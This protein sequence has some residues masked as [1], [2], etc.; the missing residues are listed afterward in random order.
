MNNVDREFVINS[1]G[2][3]INSDNSLSELLFGCVRI[4]RKYNDGI[5]EEERKEFVDILKKFNA[6][7][8]LNSVLYLFSDPKKLESFINKIETDKLRD[9]LNKTFK[10]YTNLSGLLYDCVKIYLNYNGER[11]SEQD[12]IREEKFISILKEYNECIGLEFVLDY[13]GD[14]KRLE[15]FIKNNEL[16]R[17]SPESK[18]GIKYKLEG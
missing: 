6:C 12:E 11:N 1:L 15:S 8:N 17:K 2:K 9:D 7:K 3:V 13:F 10:N 4:Y 5:D 18:E 16:G 14:R